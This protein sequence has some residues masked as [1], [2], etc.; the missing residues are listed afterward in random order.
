MRKDLIES[1]ETKKMLTNMRPSR[2]LHKRG[3]WQRREHNFNGVLS[4]FNGGLS[5]FNGGSFNGDLSDFHGGSFNGG[6]SS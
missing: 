6:L 5:G 3:F 2:G 4:G 1:K